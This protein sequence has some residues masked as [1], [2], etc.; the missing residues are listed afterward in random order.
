MECHL[1]YGTLFE[2]KAGFS[3]AFD[4]YYRPVSDFCLATLNSSLNRN[5]RNRN[6]TKNHFN[7]AIAVL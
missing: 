5:L 7:F 6:F 2:E 4:Y 1:L 3:K